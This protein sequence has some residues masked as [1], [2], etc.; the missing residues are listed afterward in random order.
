VLG[1]A[2]TKDGMLWD[3]FIRAKLRAVAWLGVDRW[4]GPC[5]LLLDALDDAG[6]SWPTVKETLRLTLG[7]SSPAG[8]RDD[9]E[10][11]RE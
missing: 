3:E 11:D 10:G 9:I 1:Y 2:L 7:L 5:E 8:S 4:V 6:V